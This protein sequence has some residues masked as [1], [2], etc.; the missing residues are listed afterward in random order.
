MQL[1]NVYRRL[2]ST[3]TII[4]QYVHTIKKYI[5]FFFNQQPFYL[6]SYPLL[7][8]FRSSFKIN[9]TTVGCVIII[10]K[11]NVI[12][13]VSGLPRS[14]LGPF[15]LSHCFLSYLIITL[16]LSSPLPLCTV[17]KLRVK[18]VL[19]NFLEYFWM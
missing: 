16:H 10:L 4:P 11:L 6:I 17:C 3:S 13:H 9:S 18:P 7:Y 1:H 19:Y 12:T 15:N 8:T 2:P 14:V 5:Y